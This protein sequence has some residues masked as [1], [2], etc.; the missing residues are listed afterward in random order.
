MKNIGNFGQP[1]FPDT[2]CNADIGSYGQ[3]RGERDQKRHNFAVCADRSQR[4]GVGKVS[5]HGSIG[6][7]EKLLQH[8]A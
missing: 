8:T 3:S 2:F 6:G 1:V 7:I 4:V 5:H